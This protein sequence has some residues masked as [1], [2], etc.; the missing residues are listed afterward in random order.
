M[1]IRAALVTTALLVT[2][3]GCRKPPASNAI[4]GTGSVPPATTPA[5]AAID[6]R[7]FTAPQ[8][9][10]LIADQTGGPVSLTPA[11]PNKFTG[12]RQVPGDTLRVP[13]TV[14]VEEGRVII[15]TR[16]GGLTS[17]QIITPRGLVTD[18]LRESPRT[19]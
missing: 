3:I 15:E 7:T 11:G 10:I 13:V 6:Y 9:E 4:P 1:T 5:A 17:R 12:T 2:L 19:P 16:G 14:T 18:D 8:L